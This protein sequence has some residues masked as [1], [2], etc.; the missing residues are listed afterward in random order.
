MHL[1]ALAII[2]NLRHTI[3]L[4]L[5]IFF[6]SIVMAFIVY[7]TLY[8]FMTLNLLTLL[9]FFFKKGYDRSEYLHLRGFLFG[10]YADIWKYYTWI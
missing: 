9:F 10:R 1:C 4:H 2:P 5:D 7:L 6:S 3:A 8:I